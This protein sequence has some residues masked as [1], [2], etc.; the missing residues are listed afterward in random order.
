MANKEVD[1]YIDELDITVTC[2]I[3]ENSPPLLSIGRL[4]RVNGY[5]FMQKGNEDPE[6]I[7]AHNTM[8]TQLKTKNDVP[9]LLPESTNEKLEHTPVNSPR[10]NYRA[11]KPTKK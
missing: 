5:T 3:V 2:Y 9:F 10:A 8:A 1:I 6:L 4:C 7:D 11:E